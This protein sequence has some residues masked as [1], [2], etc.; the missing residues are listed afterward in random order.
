[1]QA[2]EVVLARIEKSGADGGIAFATLD[3]TREWLLERD[4][5]F[6]AARAYA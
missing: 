6:H 2:R 4:E 3:G 5:S 1:M